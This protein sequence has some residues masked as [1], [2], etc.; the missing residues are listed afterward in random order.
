M[1][2]TGEDDSL[3]DSNSLKKQDSDHPIENSKELNARKA[4][5]NVLDNEKTSDEQESE[6]S[7][8]RRLK[9]SSSTAPA[10]K[11]LADNEKQSEEFPYQ[12]CHGVDDPALHG[13][14]PSN[15]AVVASENNKESDIKISPSN[16]LES[17]SSDVVPA[18]PTR[19]HPDETCTKKSGRQK[20][21]DSSD[22]DI[23]QSAD[24]ASKMA[25][26]TIDSGVKSIKLS[27]KKLPSVCSDENKTSNVVVVSVKDNN[28]SDSEIK[29]S[30]QSARKVSGNKINNDASSSK[31]SLARKK[32]GRGKDLTKEDTPKA[33]AK[34]EKV[35]TYWLQYIIPVISVIRYK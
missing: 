14:Y 29:P 27:E 7:T 33:A 32:H 17:K 21:K 30:K 11:S 3:A 26:G 9:N 2:Q 10:D 34:D 1:K 22:K 19:G 23:I 28:T 4:K 5:H 15:E 18:S 25:D 16:A 31:H 35:N 20:K 8:K 12:K 6:Q 24:D 13:E